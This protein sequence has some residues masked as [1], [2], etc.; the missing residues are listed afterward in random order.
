MSTQER[1]ISSASQNEEL[2]Q[3]L[4]ETDY[5]SSAL[6][7]TNA[8]IRDIESQIATETKTL[9]ALTKR[10]NEELHDH[11]K[12]RD[13]RMRRLAYKMSGKKEKFE[14]TAEKEEREYHDALQEKFHAE[15]RLQSL[16][17]RLQSGKTQ[18]AEY[19]QVVAR[20]QKYQTDLKAL[21]NSIFAGPTAE[22]PEED[23]AERVVEEAQHRYHSV[24]APLQAE[25]QVLHLLSD[26]DN[27]M[28]ASH[29]SIQDALHF[30]RADMLGFG[31]AM[32]DMHE[33]NSLSVAQSNADQAG[34]LVDMARRTQPLVQPLSH[35]EIARGNFMSDVLFDN[36]F[37]DMKF[38]EKIQAAEMGLK[39]A[40][41][42]LL[43]EL[44]A[45]KSRLDRLVVEAR[46]AEEELRRARKEL[47][48]VRRE[49]FRRVNH[50]RDAA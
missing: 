43:V 47:E 30:S 42:G 33:R 22:F 39:R 38:H 40:H 19:E 50:H 18:K 17:E 26:A 6:N 29:A 31:G 11:E 28:N 41:D 4:S 13:S 45:A 25:T 16:Q 15:R 9:S 21:Y 3:A 27:Q 10:V 48:N 23:A 8:Y 7:Q 44:Q 5:A 34:M 12:Y 37:A 35:V 2:L 36:V 14:A 46:D 24:Q 49:V 32:A 1:I 20:H